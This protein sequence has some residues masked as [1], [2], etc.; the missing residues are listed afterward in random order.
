MTPDVVI[1]GWEVIAAAEMPPDI[2]K[3]A[4]VGERGLPSMRAKQNDSATV[5]EA[6]TGT[7]WSSSETGASKR[8]GK[9]LI[10]KGGLSRLCHQRRWDSIHKSSRCFAPVMEGERKWTYFFYFSV[11]NFCSMDAGNH[12]YIGVEGKGE[13]QWEGGDFFTIR[14]LW[15]KIWSYSTQN[16]IKNNLN[17]I[18]TKTKSVQKNYF[19]IEK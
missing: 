4:T 11:G 16:K 5:P 9:R 7:W 18:L 1:N 19:V 14:I 2:P 12:N 15:V 3:H 10:L 8:K 6:A 17:K 13:I